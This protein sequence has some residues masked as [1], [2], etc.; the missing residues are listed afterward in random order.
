MSPRGPLTCFADL[1]N[2]WPC[3]RWRV[4][5]RIALSLTRPSA[6]TNG[7]ELRHGSQEVIGMMVLRIWKLFESPSKLQKLF[8]PL[9][10]TCQYGIVGNTTNN[11]YC[12]YINKRFPRSRRRVATS[13]NIQYGSL[14]QLGKVTKQLSS[15]TYDFMLCI[16]VCLYP[17]LLEDRSWNWP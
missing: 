4:L 8:G 2:P 13:Q 14:E 1:T 11:T 9:D 12:S 16:C 10:W 17:V 7:M 6:T 3:G 5:A 15:S